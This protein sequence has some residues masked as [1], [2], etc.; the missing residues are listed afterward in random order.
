[1]VNQEEMEIRKTAL[2]IASFIVKDLAE[3]YPPENYE[4]ITMPGAGPFSV[5]PRSTV[6]A[7]EQLTEMMMNLAS[8]LLGEERP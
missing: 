7:A 2:E 8:W 4:I 3:A 1:M 6:T 5:A